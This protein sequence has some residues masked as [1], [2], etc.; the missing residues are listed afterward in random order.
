MLSTAIVIFREAFEIALILGV[1]LAA[2]RGLPKRSHYVWG[3]FL[4]GAIGASL[5]SLF[6]DTISSGF[7]GVGQ[8][9][10]NAAILFAAAFFIG[11]TVVWMRTHAHVMVTKIKTVGKAVAENQTPYFALSLVIGLAVLREG[12]E[13]A[14]FTYSMVAAGQHAGDIILG[15]LLGAAAGAGMGALLYFG[16]IK[17][18]TKHLFTVTSGL[19]TLVVS[20]LTAVGCGF[21]VAAGYLSDFSATVWD[22]SNLLSENS[23]AGQTLHVLIGYIEQPMQIQ[24]IAYLGTLL[25]LLI[26]MRVLAH[27]KA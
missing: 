27:S 26:L 7:E 11:W 25:T 6:I 2:T 17:I 14:L 13:I 21:L 19:L 1:V 3:G 10:M 23:L 4:G 15:S 5:I 24:V 18:P 9:L 16:L 8:E 12:A 22:T 20:G